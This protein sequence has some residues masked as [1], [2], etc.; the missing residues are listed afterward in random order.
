MVSQATD[1]EW[2]SL[3][4]SQN[5]LKTL[6]PT[7][8]TQL[9]NYSAS[10][11]GVVSAHDMRWG[12][13]GRT[14]PQVRIGQQFLR[15]R[16]FCPSRCS[17]AA[18]ATCTSRSDRF[19]DQQ[20]PSSCRRRRRTSWGCSAGSR[21]PRLS[22]RSQLGESPVRHERSE[23][24]RRRRRVCFAGRSAEHIHPLSH[25]IKAADWWVGPAA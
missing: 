20:Q 19:G 5:P 12:S 6:R 21:D 11:G 17:A 23:A 25:R 3:E 22:R 15:R 24:W 9:V 1:Q 2:K 18:A 10:T 7:Y 14:I 13:G 8:N 4:S 16:C